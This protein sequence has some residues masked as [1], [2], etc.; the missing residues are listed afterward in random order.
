MFTINNKQTHIV[1]TRGYLR[2]PHLP[3]LTV[4]SLI[5]Y[6][7]Q[8][9]HL[10]YRSNVFKAVVNA[11]EEEKH[12]VHTLVLLPAHIPLA[13]MS[14]LV[15]MHVC[16]CVSVFVSATHVCVRCKFLS[17]NKEWVDTWL[18]EIWPKYS[19]LSPPHGRM[20]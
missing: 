8:L 11:F 13:G 6:I 12:A 15:C 3:N 1:L 19:S 2:S 4:Y 20:H 14:V 7:Y 18:H 9:A 5:S 10:V 16:E 17:Y